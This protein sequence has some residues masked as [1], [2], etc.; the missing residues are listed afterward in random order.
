[1][2]SDYGSTVQEQIL[3]D[4]LNNATSKPIIKT[5]YYDEAGSTWS[6][7]EDMESRNIKFSTENDRYLSYSFVPPSEEIKFTLN[8]FGQVYSTGSGDA[9]ASILKKNLLRKCLKWKRN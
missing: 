3:Y 2:K 7:F 6:D 5:Q 9:K 8:N 1:M 4:V